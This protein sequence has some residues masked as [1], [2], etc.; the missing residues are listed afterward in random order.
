MSPT[1]LLAAQNQTF[2]EDHG[3]EVSAAITM[4][5]AIAIA[6]IVDRLVFGSAE[7]AASKV[8]TDVFS[9]EAR[10]RLRVFRRLLFVAIIVIGIALALS[11]FGEIK[12]LATGVLASTA[13]L[14]L[15]I[16][17][18]G[19]QMIANAVAGMIVAITQPVRIGDL[20]TIE[21][22][23]GRIA[24][25]SL[26]YTEIDTEDGSR[27]L[28][29]NEKLTSNVVLNRSS[30]SARAP[31]AVRITIPPGIDISAAR[32]AIE[33]AGA[34]SVVLTS[35]EFDRAELEVHAERDPSKARRAQEFDLRETAQSALREAGLLAQ[36]S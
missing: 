13:V 14:G 4:V 3:N 7:K 5:I 20:V 22:R 35:L 18:A 19:R 21:D 15:V 2:W 16:G 24:D 34:R 26:T 25:I 32:E 31:A 1:F 36:P 30:G 29:P 27:V 10:T 8:D 9:R 12:R 11:Q 28:V 23:D 6:V 17:F 33:G